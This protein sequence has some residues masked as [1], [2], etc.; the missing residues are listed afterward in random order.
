MVQYCDLSIR[1]N[2]YFLY[3]IWS[4]VL[5]SWKCFREG[6]FWISAWGVAWLPVKPTV[7]LEDRNFQSTS[8]PPP[9]PPGKGEGLE[10]KSV[11]NDEWFN[12]SCLCDKSSIK[13]SKD[14]VWRV[15][16]LVTTWRLGRVVHLER[17][18]KLL[19]LSSCLVRCISSSSCWFVFFNILL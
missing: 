6:G 2:K 10:V 19:A 3:N 13:T 15:S 5:S 7:W 18:W 4:L 8:R 17:A 12:Q 14:R 1:P 16:G 9:Q 11:A